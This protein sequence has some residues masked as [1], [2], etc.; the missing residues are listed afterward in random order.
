VGARWTIRLYSSLFRHYILFIANK[1]LSPYVSTLYAFMIEIN[2]LS[3]HFFIIINR[4]NTLDL[5]IM[6]TLP[7]MKNYINLLTIKGDHI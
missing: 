7:K 1:L 6:Q 4:I 2:S 5:I 3:L